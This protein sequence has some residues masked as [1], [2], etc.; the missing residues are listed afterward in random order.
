MEHA[1]DY[2]PKHYREFDWVIPM[3]GDGHYL[4]NLMKSFIEINWVTYFSYLTRQMGWETEKA[5]QAAKA[6]SDTHKTFQL[7]CIFYYGSLQAAVAC[8]INRPR[9]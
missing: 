5:Q 1:Y 9:L 7:L 6:C 2:E 8:N 3:I 4:M